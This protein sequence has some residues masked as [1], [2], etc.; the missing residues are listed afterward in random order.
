M[1]P[2]INI[3]IA[4]VMKT[5]SQG[6]TSIGNTKGSRGMALIHRTRMDNLKQ[7]SQEYEEFG[8]ST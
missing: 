6:V 8:L 5:R 7:M 3:T 2:M 4:V 1:I